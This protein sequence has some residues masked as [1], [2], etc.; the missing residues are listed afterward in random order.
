MHNQTIER[1]A[2]LILK[3]LRDE[4]S[5]EEREEF[6][7][8]LHATAENKALLESFATF[9]DLTQALADYAINKSR[10][11]DQIGTSISLKQ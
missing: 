7:L 4:L 1:T 10:I 5:R 11:W 9:G 8:W 6:E 2:E 3:Y